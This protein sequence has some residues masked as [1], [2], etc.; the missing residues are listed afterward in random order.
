[1]T[2][3]DVWTLLT[4]AGQKPIGKL[5][6]RIFWFQKKVRITAVNLPET[7]AQFEND[8]IFTFIDGDGR[9]L[10]NIA[11][12][13]FHLAR[14]NSVI[15][16][17]GVDWENKQKFAEETKRVAEKYYV[18]TPSYWFPMEPHFMTP[19]FQRLPQWAR[20]KLVQNLALGWYKK[21][22]NYEMA[23]AAVE[24]CDLLTKKEMKKLFP[25][26]NLHKEKIGFLTKSFV[27]IKG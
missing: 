19:G 7:T 10:P 17:V 20:I 11:D 15:E 26:A 9:D 18:Q 8:E 14:S 4:L 21:T 12:K 22:P 3:T 2:S 13:S 5:S 23:K 24:G 25:D 1:M 6:P 27:V 16:H